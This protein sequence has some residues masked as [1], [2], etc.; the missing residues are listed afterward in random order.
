MIGLGRELNFLGKSGYMHLT[1]ILWVYTGFLAS[2]RE[3]YGLR[4]GRLSTQILDIKEGEV[5]TCK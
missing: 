4:K 1:C 3:I 5:S 2:Q